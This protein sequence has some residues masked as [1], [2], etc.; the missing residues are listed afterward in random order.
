MGERALAV[1]LSEASSPELIAAFDDPDPST[2]I[3]PIAERVRFFFQA[4]DGIRGADVTGVQTCA[5]PISHAPATVMTSPCGSWGWTPP[6]ATSQGSLRGW[7]QAG[8]TFPPTR[9]ACAGTPHA[10]T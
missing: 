1:A 5:L 6:S 2:T 7:R 8:T 10:A 3:Q 4:E 9:S